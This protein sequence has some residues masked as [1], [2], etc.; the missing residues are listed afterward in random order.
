MSSNVLPLQYLYLNLSVRRRRPGSA[1][2]PLGEKFDKGVKSPFQALATKAETVS[3]IRAQPC[4]RSAACY[5]RLEIWETQSPAEG[6][7]I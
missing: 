6:P 4:A 3:D 5:F 7:K 1:V 2:I